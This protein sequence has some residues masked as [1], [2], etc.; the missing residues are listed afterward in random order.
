MVA[1]ADSIK[2]STS[3]ASMRAVLKT[4]DLSARWMPLT[5]VAKAFIC[6]TPS[7]IV[8]CVRNTPAN[9]CMV[10]RMSLA[11]SC[12]YSPP[13][14]ASNLFKRASVKSAALAGSVLCVLVFSALS[15]MWLPA[16][17]PNTNKSSNELVPKRLA[18]CTLTHEHSPTAYKPFTTALELPFFGTTTWPWMLVGM[19]PI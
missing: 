5:R 1:M 12:A 8:V 3:S 11:T 7:S 14:V 2:L 16:A 19:P 4:L 10:L 15:T 9:C 17:R 6:D 18:P 13:V